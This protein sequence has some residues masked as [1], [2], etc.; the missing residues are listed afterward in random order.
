MQDVYC[1]SWTSVLQAD[2]SDRQKWNLFH[3]C[4]QKIIQRL[5]SLLWWFCLLLLKTVL[6]C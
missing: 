5:N 1:G 3:Y 6:I 2:K 4:L